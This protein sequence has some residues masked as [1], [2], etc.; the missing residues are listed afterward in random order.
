MLRTP[1]LSISNGKHQ[2]LPTDERE[3][4]SALQRDAEQ[5]GV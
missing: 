5:M 4:E 1:A 3:L 2:V